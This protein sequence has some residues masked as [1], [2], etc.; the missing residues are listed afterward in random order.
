MDESRVDVVVEG[1]G[2]REGGGQEVSEMAATA[3]FL[4]SIPP[5]P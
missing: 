3:F 1:K 5:S 4:Q 2:G